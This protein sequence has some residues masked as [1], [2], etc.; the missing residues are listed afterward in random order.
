MF[1]NLTHRDV[2]LPVVS[3]LI[4]FHPQKF[5]SRTQRLSFNADCP[6][7]DELSNTARKAQ[8]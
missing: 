1:N 7:L 6:S 3:Q 4:P 8:N 5:A 2:I